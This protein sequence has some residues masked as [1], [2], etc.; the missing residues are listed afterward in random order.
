[1]VP[2]EPAGRAE[3][4]AASGTERGWAEL[5][6]SPDKKAVFCH[7]KARFD[8]ARCG[9]DDFPE[10]FPVPGA[11]GCEEREGELPR[12]RSEEESRIRL[13]CDAVPGRSRFRAQLCQAERSVFCLFSEIRAAGED[14]C[15]G[16]PGRD[17]EF[18]GGPVC[19]GCIPPV[20]GHGGDPGTGHE[21]ADRG[22]KRFRD[23][24]GTASVMQAVNQAKGTGLSK[25]GDGQAAG[26]VRG[27]E[28]PA[29]RVTCPEA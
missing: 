24:H 11:A 28:E 14:P 6:V 17:C 10:H 7:E 29:G 8:A 25:P 12:F 19:A 9:T 3:E 22:E 16:A 4:R 27:A 1:M 26:R 18:R 23:A 15:R 2:Q 13:A 20:F 21:Q 5:F